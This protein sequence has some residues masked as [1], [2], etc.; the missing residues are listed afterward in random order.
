VANEPQKKSWQSDV[1]KLL[2]RAAQVAVES[3]VD[4]E[5]FM[6]DA[7]QSYFDARP[8]MREYL[9]EMQLRATLQQMR[10]D[11]RIATA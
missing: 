7:A 11:G 6:K 8:G 5:A 10:D 2:A 1:G 4:M 3:D 9:E